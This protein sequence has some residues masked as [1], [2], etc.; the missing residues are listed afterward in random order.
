LRGT[1][2]TKSTDGEGTNALVALAQNGDATEDISPVRV[3]R[4]SR[5][6]NTI[7]A[8]IEAAGRPLSPQEVFEATQL[9]VA[10]VGLSTVYRNLR[11]LLEAGEVQAVTL[12]GDSARYELA[13]CGGGEWGQAACRRIVAMSTVWGSCWMRTG[14]AVAF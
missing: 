13:G 8:V 10:S 5:Q 1:E 2:P 3:S 6:R 7:R 9:E 12:P 14:F 4:A 11:L